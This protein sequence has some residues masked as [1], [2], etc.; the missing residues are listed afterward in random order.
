MAN[1]ATK[2][3]L[4]SGGILGVPSA[5]LISGKNLFPP[6]LSLNGGTFAVTADTYYCYPIYIDKIQSFSGTR[7][8]NSGTG[9]SGK[10]IKIALYND[11]GTLAKNFGE[12]TLTGSSAVLSFASSWTPTRVGWYELRI[13]SDSA[14][15][16]YTMGNVT[17]VSSAGYFGLPVMNSLFGLI[18][19]S[20]NANYNQ[21]GYAGDSVAGTYANFPES[22]ALT[23]TAS[24]DGRGNACPAVCLYK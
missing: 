1:V 8:T 15:T 9:D 10:K 22:T 5:P 14:P 17:Q 3:G 20:W 21:Y 7:C 16:L 6:H 11:D 13:V 23:A 19:S 18:A 24:F 4:S 2:F 12:A